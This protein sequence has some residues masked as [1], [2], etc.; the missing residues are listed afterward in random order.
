MLGPT[1]ASF[2]IPLDDLG[3]VD[4]AFVDGTDGDKLSDGGKFDDD[5]L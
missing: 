4:L 5:I 2:F 3:F 1:G